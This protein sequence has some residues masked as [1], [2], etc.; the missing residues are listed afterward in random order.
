MLKINFKKVENIIQE[1]AKTVIL[2]RFR[3]LE[4]RRYI[5]QIRRQ[6]GHNCRQRG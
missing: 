5:I 6:P 3:K 1:V 4:K 2:P